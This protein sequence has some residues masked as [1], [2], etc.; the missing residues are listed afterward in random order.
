MNGARQV[1]MSDGFEGASVDTIAK[2]A[3]VSKATLYSY[4]ADKRLLFMEVAT[5]ECGKQAAAAIDSLDMDD[6]PEHVLSTAGS[7]MLRFLLS[8]FGQRVFRIC[9]AETDRFPELGQR[10]WDS[11]PGQVERTLRRYFDHAIARGE[12][13]IDDKSLAAHQFAELCKAELFPRLV[14][15]MQTEF[16]E[17]ERAR[18]VKGAVEMFMARYGT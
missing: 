18:V 9:V 1:F 4:F 13:K 7:H 15:G 16:S 14:F 5:C 10:F 3:G 8:E 12:L 17:A 2:C 6:K 11:G